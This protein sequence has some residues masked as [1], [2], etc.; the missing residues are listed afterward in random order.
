MAD[1]NGVLTA[2]TYTAGTLDLVTNVGAVGRSFSVATRVSITSGSN[3][4]TKTFT[5][6][7]LDKTGKKLQTE[8]I[9]GPNATIVHSTLTFRSIEKI[10]LDI[11]STGA[12]VTVGITGAVVLP[13]PQYLAT[14][15]TTSTSDS[16]VITGTDRNDDILTETIACTDVTAVEGVKLFKSIDKVVAD[17]VMVAVVF[18]LNGFF[19]T[20]WFGLDLHANNFNVSVAF[21]DATTGT[22]SVVGTNDDINASTFDENTATTHVTLESGGDLTGLT[23]DDLGQ[24][25]VP[26][27]AIRLQ[28]TGEVAATGTV[29][30]DII[31]AA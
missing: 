2:D 17:G 25:T 9:T 21:D 20:Q 30:L 11:T 6:T 1:P 5:V 23:A 7:G 14:N 3:E 4:S 26:V 15:C 24:I 27:R 29:G 8:K 18:G 13:I 28:N 22:F 12:D 31:Q 19:A 10:A 16:L